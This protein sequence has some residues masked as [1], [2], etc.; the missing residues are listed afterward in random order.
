[1]NWEYLVVHVKNYMDEHYLNAYGDE[2]WELAAIVKTSKT[3]RKYT[4]KRPKQK[5]EGIS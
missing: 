4:F 2:R 1:M 5:D 3:E